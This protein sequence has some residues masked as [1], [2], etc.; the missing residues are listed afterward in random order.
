MGV[1]KSHQ[2]EVYT[3]ERLEYSYLKSRRQTLRNPDQQ[4]TTLPL[5]Q[6]EEASMEQWEDMLD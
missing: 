1:Y 4:K 6:F 3:T 2:V 5:V